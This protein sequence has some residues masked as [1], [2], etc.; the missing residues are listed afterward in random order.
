M[1]S[2]TLT[3]DTTVVPA[4]AELDGTSG[5]APKEWQSCHG[6]GGQPWAMG[7][8]KGDNISRSY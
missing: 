3:H 1:F 7:S 6:E 2:S 4:Q 8:D 5:V